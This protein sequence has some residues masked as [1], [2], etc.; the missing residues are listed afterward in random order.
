MGVL[1]DYFR[2][3]D[4]AAAVRLMKDF[5]GGPFAVSRG[6]IA[7]DAVDLKGIEPTVTLGKLVS[8]VRQVDWEVSLVDLE[9]LWSEDEQDGPWLM[10]L[11]RAT[12]DTL[13][14]ISNAQVLELSAQWGRIEELAWSGP[15]SDDEMLPV[16][17]K[18][19]ALAQRARD[20]GED[21]YC[22]CCL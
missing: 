1:Y 2:A 16:I 7:V 14:S 5:E 20:A 19:A 15:L 13:A 4:D 22:W 8:F 17:E 9:L 11:D 6:G 21:L 12:R 3:K 10:S 18:V